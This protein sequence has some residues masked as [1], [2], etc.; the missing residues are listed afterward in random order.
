MSTNLSGQLLIASPYL[1]DGNFLRSVIFM[2]RHDVEGAFGLLI[3]RPTDR[4]FRDLIDSSAV[5]GNLRDDDAIYRGGPVDGPLLALHDLAGV[6]EPCGPF[7]PTGELLS[8]GQSHN[9][10]AKYTVHDHPAEA[11]GSMSI[12]LGN[13]PA[14]ITGDDDHL[15]ILLRRP[16]ARVRYVSDYSGWGPGQ[17]DE[18]LRM[19]GWLAGEADPD[20]I[21]GDP[22]EAWEKAVKQCGKDILAEMAPGVRFGDPTMN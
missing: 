12:E 3:N 15:R 8:P 5:E 9:Q 6:G 19:G 1:N 13:P 14:W 22:N 16:E 11:F 10:G 18:E 4:R 7:D 17:L 21:F 20:I 2:V